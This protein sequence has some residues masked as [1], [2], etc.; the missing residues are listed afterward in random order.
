MAIKFDN[1]DSRSTR[2]RRKT[3]V[4]EVEYP[5]RS[6]RFLALLGA[7]FGIKFILIIP[8]I[9]VIG[10]LGTIQ[11][12]LNYFGYWAVLITGRYPRSLFNFGVGVTRWS[13]RLEAWMNGWT[14]S[15]PSF[16]LD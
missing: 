15:Y 16:R 12:I 6:S 5:Q 10:F 2:S 1:K 8:H 7:L 13:I 9:I 4:F 14:D 11:A 3:I